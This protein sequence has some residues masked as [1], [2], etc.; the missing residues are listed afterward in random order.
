[1]T[2]TEVENKETEEKSP[3]ILVFLGWSGPLADAAQR[4]ACRAGRSQPCTA[5]SNMR[6]TSASNFDTAH[7]VSRRRFQ[8]AF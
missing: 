1:L 4:R 8:G 3:E 5:P 6:M 2:S 7:R